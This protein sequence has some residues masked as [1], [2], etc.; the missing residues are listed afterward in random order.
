VSSY[1]T[2]GSALERARPFWSRA[3]NA[4]RGGALSV[5][6]R[7][8]RTPGPGVRIVHY[9]YVFDDERERFARQLQYLAREFSPVSLSEAVERLQLGRT[10]GD[11]I[12]VTFDDGFQNQLDNAAPLLAEHGF[13]ACFFLVTDLLGASPERARRLERERL[14]LPLP[15]E[16]LDWEGAERL[17]EHGHEV[18]SHTVSH[19]DLTSLPPAELERELEV[20]RE[21]LSKRLGTVRHVSA[22]YGERSRFSDRVAAAARE[23]GYESCATAIRGRNTSA[24]DLYSLRRHHL[25]ARWPM[26]EV[27]YFLT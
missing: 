18:G 5:L 26:H 11:E 7:F 25:S 12:V 21:E 17:L 8:P 22:P 1:V 27:E 23:A 4:V 2:E 14:H 15:V 10:E 13:S 16:P 19:P 20:S 24:L 9:H 3:R 6:S